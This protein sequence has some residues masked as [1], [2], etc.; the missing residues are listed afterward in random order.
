[1]LSHPPMYHGTPTTFVTRID[2][3]EGSRDCSGIRLL[4]LN[5]G[6]II[7]REDAYTRVRAGMVIHSGSDMGP[8]L[9]AVSREGR[10]YVRT[11]SSDTSHDPLLM[12]PRGY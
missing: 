6:E 12:L 4:T 10:R 8:V 2:V 7:M 5:T 3:E 11:M 9:I 1:M